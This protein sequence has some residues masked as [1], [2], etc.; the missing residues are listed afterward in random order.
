MV[1]ELRQTLLVD[2]HAEYVLAISKASDPRSDGDCEL[3]AGAASPPP[4]THCI[5]LSSPL[6]LQSKTS[7]AYYATE[8]FRMSGVY[9]GLSALYLLGKMEAMDQDEVVAWVLSCQHPCGGFRG[10]ERHDPHLLYTLSALQIL[11]LYDQLHRIDADAVAACEG[12]FFISAI[13]VPSF[14]QFHF[15]YIPSAC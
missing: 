3:H 12:C 15:P 7:F 8:H 4:L 5:S 6:P 9:W 11:A 14:M 2:K 10:S 13:F 1:H